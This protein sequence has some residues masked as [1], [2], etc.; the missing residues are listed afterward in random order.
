M[1]EEVEDMSLENPQSVVFAQVLT[2]SMLNWFTFA[3][4]IP[5]TVTNGGTNECVVKIQFAYGSQKRPRNCINSNFLR[6]SSET[7]STNFW[8]SF[9]LRIP[10][11]VTDG[12]TNG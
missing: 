12:A 10:N 7:Q 9:P 1:R 6:K 2:N 4:G 3:L 8:L 5:N 11:R